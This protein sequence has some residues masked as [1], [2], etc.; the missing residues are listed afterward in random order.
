MTSEDE[1]I[2][3]ED[4]LSFID[5]AI[6]DTTFNRIL[7]YAGYLIL[8][9][10]FL[11]L[12]IAPWVTYIRNFPIKIDSFEEF[13]TKVGIE[14]PFSADFKRTDLP[15]DSEF[16]GSFI[17]EYQ[18]HYVWVAACPPDATH[19]VAYNFAEGFYEKISESTDVP[20]ADFCL[21]YHRISAPNA[22]APIAVFIMYG[23]LVALLV[24]DIRYL[25]DIGRH[26]IRKYLAGFDEDYFAIFN[27]ELA[28]GKVLQ[29]NNTYLSPTLLVSRTRT[30]LYVTRIADLAWVYPKKE[31]VKF[32]F[33]PLWASYNIFVTPIEGKRWNVSVAN[34]L[35]SVVALVEKIK[36]FAPW[37]ATGY[38]RKTLTLFELDKNT[39]LKDIEERKTQILHKDKI[40]LDKPD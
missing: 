6:G 19:P 36:E 20:L 12:V 40:N 18:G 23:W 28:D 21:I 25:K 15:V 39:L 14:R 32:A 16:E 30:K 22:S 29:L 11:Y 17:A 8:G 24:R 2:E 10:Y 9:L 31:H 34:D 26:P 3:L 1:I 27:E 5:D 38:D 33:I 4:D 7:S 13:Y 37:I 35:E